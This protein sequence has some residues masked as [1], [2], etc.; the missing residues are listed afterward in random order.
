MPFTPSHAVV[1]LP[2]IRTPLVPAAIAVGAM[3]PDLPL[4]VRGLPLH[5][6]ATHSFAWLPATVV[7]ALLLL[8]VWRCVLRP[9]ARELSPRWLA[10]RLPGE[11]DAGAGRSLR[12]TFAIVPG[13]P[14]RVSW[15]GMLL[16][17]AS[18]VIGVVSHIVWDLFTHEARWG[19]EVVPALAA[20]WG[21]L[22]GFKW[23]QHGSSVLGLA[24]IAGWL[25]LWLVRREAEASVV[26]TLPGWVR[27]GWWASLPAVLVAAWVW[28]LA[29]YGGLDAGFTAAH[30]GYRVLP[31]ACAV[32]GAVTVAA[33]IAAQVRRTRSVTAR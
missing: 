7:V 8:V 26:R 3:T 12:E 2:F 1:A 19:T 4:F 24:I 21:P 6:G 22:R 30:L 23:L 9:A 15:S 20:E 32:W 18:L 31:P 25:L 33:C 5:Y 29:V 28:G 17:V 27:W 14:S 13:P 10:A 11:W 16:L